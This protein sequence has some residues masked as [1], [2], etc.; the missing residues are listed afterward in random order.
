MPMQYIVDW[1]TGGAMLAG[2]DKSLKL[3]QETAVDDFLVVLGDREWGGD[4][5]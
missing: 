1:A 4:A 3:K 2:S 5:F